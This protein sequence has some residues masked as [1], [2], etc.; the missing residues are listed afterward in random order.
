MKSDDNNGQQKRKGIDNSI[1]MN[2]DRPTW[3]V[4]KTTDTKI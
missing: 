2:D 1:Y 3:R 4:E